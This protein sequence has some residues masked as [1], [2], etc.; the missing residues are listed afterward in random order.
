MAKIL[1]AK[2][3]SISFD[4]T[5]DISHQEQMSEIVRYVDTNNGKCTV[6]E[7]FLAFIKT[8]KKNGSG[9]TDEIVN[10]LSKDGLIQSDCRGQS[11]DNGDN[12]AGKY[13]GVQA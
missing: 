13:Q 10:K 8:D 2:Y 7:S 4:C 1:Q 3:Y 5:P 11:Y 6:E 12:M 9:L